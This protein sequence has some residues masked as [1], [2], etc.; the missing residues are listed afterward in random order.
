[1]KIPKKRKLQRKTNY[2]TRLKLLKSGIPRIVV[3]KTNTYLVVQYVI[4]NESKDKVVLSVSSRELL[5]NGWPKELKGSLKN[6]PAAYLTGYLAGKKIIEKS[7]DKV[8]LD[9]GLQRSIAGN[10]LFAVL[11]GLV[12]AGVNIAHDKKV[13]PNDERISGKHLKE[14]VQKEIIKVKGKIV[15]NG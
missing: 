3:R 1:M 13:F 8:I 15:K 2:S 7:K 6:M 9:L 10:R 4:S 5:K 11:K 12:D 14:N